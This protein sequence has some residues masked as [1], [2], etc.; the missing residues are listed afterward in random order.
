MRNFQIL[1]EARVDDETGIIQLS[2]SDDIG[3]RPRLAMRRE[4]N[5]LSISASYGPLEIAMRLE[6]LQVERVFSNLH[7]VKGLQTTRQI[8]TGQAYIAAGLQED[9]G[10]AIRPTIVADATGHLSFNLALTNAAR[11][12]LFEWLSIENRNILNLS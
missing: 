2:V 5:Y 4:G 10:L 7:P 3:Q 9:G 6:Y 8:G 11:R 12:A 1:D